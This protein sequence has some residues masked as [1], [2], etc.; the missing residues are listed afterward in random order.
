METGGDSGFD[1]GKQRWK[2]TG[3]VCFENPQRRGEETGVA[4][5][6]PYSIRRDRR[7]RGGGTGAFEQDAG[8]GLLDQ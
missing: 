5:P 6:T 7:I 2:V 3:L 4:R 1:L 8:R